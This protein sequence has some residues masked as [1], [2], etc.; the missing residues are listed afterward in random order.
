MTAAASQSEL[1][2]DRGLRAGI[3]ARS[4]SVV[5]PAYQEEGRLSGTVEA[6]HEFLTAR[7]Y[8]AELIVVDDGS[9]DRTS[10]LLAGLAHRFPLLRPIRFERNHGKGFAVRAGILAATRE[11]VLFSDADLS[12]PM[13]DIDRLWKEYDRGCDVVIASRRAPGA[14]LP[15]RQP[16]HRRG[17][18]R[19]FNVLVSLLGVRG[20]QD[21]QCGFKLFRTVMAR[22]IFRRVITQGFAFDVEVLLRARERG[23]RIAE[24][25]VTWTDRPGSKVSALRD[26]T[27]MVLEI[28]R[29]RRLI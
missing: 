13:T 22:Q 17:M 18:G 12:T 10:S 7:G 11:A 21:T 2:V 3:P 9:R 1:G 6:I 16:L 25:G 29:M 26:S 27:R 19:V 5:V 20:F 14:R 15:G 23:C 24:V 28:L 8:D 4:L